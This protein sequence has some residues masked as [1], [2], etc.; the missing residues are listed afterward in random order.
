MLCCR[1]L[2]TSDRGVLVRA[3]LHPVGLRISRTTIL[4]AQGEARGAGPFLYD[5]HKCHAYDR[6]HATPVGTA[7]LGRCIQPGQTRRVAPVGTRPVSTYRQSATRSLRASATIMIR[8]I[9]PRCAPT[10]WLNHF[11]SALSGW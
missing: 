11:A 7:A 10:R 5:G 2:A 9:R 3:T 8:F 4:L 1:G 6:S